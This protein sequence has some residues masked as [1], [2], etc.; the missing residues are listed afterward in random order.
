MSSWLQPQN[1]TLLWD[2]LHF[3]SWVVHVRQNSCPHAVRSVRREETNMWVLSWWRMHGMQPTHQV[4][5][6]FVFQ[7]SSVIFENFTRLVVTF[8]RYLRKCLVR[9]QKHCVFRGSCFRSGPRRCFGTCDFYIFRVEFEREARECLV[10]F[11]YSEYISSLSITQSISL[12]FQLLRVYL[13]YLS[14]T[15]SISLLLT[16]QTLSLLFPLQTLTH[17]LLKL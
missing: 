12:L 10:S 5:C 6:L 14:I 8:W 1:S 13:P 4:R 2:K 16:T 9:I 7:T 11:N 3:W 17:T 15:Q